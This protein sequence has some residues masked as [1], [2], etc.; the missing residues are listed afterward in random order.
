VLLGIVSPD[1][2][3]AYLTPRVVVD[4]PFVDRARQGRTPEARFRFAQP[5]AEGGC[6]HW[7]GDRC[8]VVDH[9]VRAPELRREPDRPLP[10]CSIR[11]SCRW[12][13]QEKASACRVCPLV[14]HDP[15]G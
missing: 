6:A 13:A 5:C 14:V 3:V 15:D 2:T 9:A 7:V 12:F 11:A 4:Q 8:E 1:G 10:R